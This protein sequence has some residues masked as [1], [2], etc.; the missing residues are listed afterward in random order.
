VAVQA[1]AVEGHIR[2]SVV[3]DA[4]AGQRCA[5]AV[6]YKKQRRKEAEWPPN[7]PSFPLIRTSS[8][9]H[10][11]PD[12]AFLQTLSLRRLSSARPVPVLIPGVGCA[13]PG[14]ETTGPNGLATARV[15]TFCR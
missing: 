9:R 1:V 11:V 2:R 14:A 15:A 10:A 5:H 13:D 3:V 8:R 4:Y 6:A 12:E 7:R